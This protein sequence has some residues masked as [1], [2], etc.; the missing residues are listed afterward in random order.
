MMVLDLQKVQ[1]WLDTTSLFQSLFQNAAQRRP[2]FNTWGKCLVAS[3]GTQMS[4]SI[5]I[6]R[7]AGGEAGGED[8]VLRFF[9]KGLSLAELERC[10]SV[11]RFAMVVAPDR[12]ALTLTIDEPGAPAVTQEYLE[13]A[14][15]V[16]CRMSSKAG[17]RPGGNASVRADL[18]RDVAAASRASAAT[19]PRFAQMVSKVDAEKPIWFVGH[20]GDLTDKL[21]AM[22]GTIAL[23]QG[24]IVQLTATYDNA[25]T[26]KHRLAELQA[27][28]ASVADRLS[29]PMPGL[30]EL[31]K[32]AAIQ[33]V[34]ADLLIRVAATAAA[35]ELASRELRQATPAVVDVP[36]RFTMEQ[37]AVAF[38]ELRKC[39]DRSSEIGDLLACGCQQDL[40]MSPTFKPAD[41]PAH[42]ADYARRVLAQHKLSDEEQQRAPFLLA[43][44]EVGAPGAA[45]L[46]MF[47]TPCMIKAI[48]ARSMEL[49]TACICRTHAIANRMAM[50]T[51]LR[52]NQDVQAALGEIVHEL[53]DA[54]LCEKQ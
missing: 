40:A 19:D 29:A 25:T 26:A 47:S 39:S 21:G 11:A 49:A 43:S 2:R 44:P 27:F 16:L 30:A 31:L 50:R 41:A 4:A 17:M 13:V 7:E 35:L 24:L 51:S 36:E 32:R 10:S 12:K 5:T 37:I 52:T 34:D 46:F 1:R 14:G 9:V 3:A 23:E 53:V 6:D 33:Q 8:L 38:N 48:K 54:K 15:G 20:A 18:E 42:C 45:M 22:A 28:Q